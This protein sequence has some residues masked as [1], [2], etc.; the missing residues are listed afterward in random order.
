MKD[1][2]SVYDEELM[3][4]A[5]SSPESERKKNDE[6]PNSEMKTDQVWNIIIQGN[7]K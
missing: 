4:S 2:S 6:R 3:K 7:L 5:P 1:D